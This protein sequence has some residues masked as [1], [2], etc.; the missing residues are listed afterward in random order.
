MRT[1]Y[2]TRYGEPDDPT[3]TQTAREADATLAAQTEKLLKCL[4]SHAKMSVLLP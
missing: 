3:L 1:L 4:R 2:G